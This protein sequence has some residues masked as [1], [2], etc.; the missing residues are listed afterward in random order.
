MHTAVSGIGLVLQLFNN[1][2]D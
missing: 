1:G 2:F